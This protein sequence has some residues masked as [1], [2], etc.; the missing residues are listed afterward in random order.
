[1]AYS[2]EQQRQDLRI[3]DTTQNSLSARVIGE[4]QELLESFVLDYVRISRMW[5]NKP[6]VNPRMVKVSAKMFKE[7]TYAP[8]ISAFQLAE[9]GKTLA[10]T[11]RMIRASIFRRRKKQVACLE[12]DVHLQPC[13]CLDLQRAKA[14]E[15]AER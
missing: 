9:Y 11:R 14:L 6:F 12:P 3:L 10:A 5:A 1:M 8:R 15:T 2:I 7:L 4:K 13:F